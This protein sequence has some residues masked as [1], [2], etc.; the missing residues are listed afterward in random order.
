ML[1]RRYRLSHLVV[2]IPLLFGAR[3]A[4]QSGH[5]LMHGYV[6]YDDVSYNE[7]TQGAIHAKIE[8]RGATEHNHALYTAVTD[9]RGSYNIPA[10][11][12]GQ[13]TLTISAPG[14]VTYKIDIY[15]P[16]DFEC[17]LATML[18]KKGGAPK[19]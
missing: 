17:R 12:A 13:Y 9:N 14:H 4:A 19:G 11:G 2:A 16:S 5:G 7:M 15:I 6:G 1:F 8:L 3:L 10:I 18:K